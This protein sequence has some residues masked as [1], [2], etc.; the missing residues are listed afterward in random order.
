MSSS[1]S[2]FANSSIK[3]WALSLASASLMGATSVE[4]LMA[5]ACMAQD[6]ASGSCCVDWTKLDLSPQQKSQI[7]SLEGQWLKDF[8]DIAPQIREEQLKLQK[9]LSEHNPDSMQIVQLQ[10]SIARRKEQLNL[11]AMQNYISKKK[12]LSEK[13]QTM[14]ERMIQNSVQRRKAQ[15]NPNSQT[16]VVPDKIQELMQKIKDVF[17]VSDNK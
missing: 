6:A 4:L 11:V 1:S 7:D 13:Q 10:Q 9:L 14:Y 17:P 3:S 15:L 8:G 5:R 2:P 12:L 16:E